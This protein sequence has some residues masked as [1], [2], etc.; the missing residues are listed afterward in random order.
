MVTYIVYGAS[1]ALTAPGLTGTNA[2]ALRVWN[3]DTG[4][5]VS[6]TGST[7]TVFISVTV[8]QITAPG[9]AITM[10]GG[11]LPSTSTFGDLWVQEIPDGIAS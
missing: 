7:L 6:N 4:T 5:I 2:T 8:W 10:S 3:N 9:A 11:T 1:T